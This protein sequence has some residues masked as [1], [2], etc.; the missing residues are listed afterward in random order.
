MFVLNR[1]CGLHEYLSHVNQ[2]F[3]IFQA[4]LHVTLYQMSMCNQRNLGIGFSELVL[5]VL[6]AI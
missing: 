4:A 1:S 2:V 6:I 5:L 3:L